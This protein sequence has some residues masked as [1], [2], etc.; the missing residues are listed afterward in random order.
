MRSSGILMHLSS[1]PSEGGIGTLGRPAREF[2]DFL[3]VAGQGFWQMLPVGHT[4]FGDSPYQSFSAFAGNPYFIDLEELAAQGL[5][6]REEFAHVDW[7]SGPGRVNYGAMYRKRFSIL[8]LGAERLLADPPGAF[9][10]F[11]RENAFWLEDYALFMALKDAQGGAAWQDWPPALRRREPEALDSFRR[12]N[13]GAIGFW[14]AVQYMFFAQWGALRDYAASRGVKLIG[15]LPI[16][17][18]PD[19]VDVWARPEL[20]QLDGDLR[21]QA[22]AGVPPDGFSADGQLWGNP[23]FDWERMAQDDYDWWAR[24]IGFLS[25]VFDVLRIDHFRGFEAYFAVP[26]GAD[27]ARDGVWRP[28]P[29]MAL[30]RAVERRIGPRPIIAEDL[31]FLTDGVRRLLAESGFPGMKVLEFAF[32]S[33][34]PSDSDYLPHNYPVRC[35][36]YIG[37]HDNDTALGWL[38]SISREDAAYARAYMRLTGQE[39]NWGMMQTLWASPAELTIVQ[40]QDVLGLGSEGRMNTPATVGDNWTWR[41][42]PGSFT[43]ALAQRLR[44][45]MALYG[46]MR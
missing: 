3:A 17:V 34:D 2:I 23:L 11:C 6:R 5:L 44:R 33:R 30:F 37:T 42:L 36:A 1:L 12:E 29:G 41:A 4:G 24:R 43:P 9:G 28:G 45:C 15:D 7:E 18:S 14:R 40:A 21:P 27:T 8:R 46:R 22:V 32:D 39:D 19:G 13:A 25:R 16:Y 10:D 31:G 38:G 26:F 35:V 20:F